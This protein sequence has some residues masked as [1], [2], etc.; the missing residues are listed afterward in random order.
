[1]MFSLVPTLFSLTKH[2][3]NMVFFPGGTGP[4]QALVFSA[5]RHILAAGGEYR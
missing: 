4:V 5:D 1:M 2:Y 3:K